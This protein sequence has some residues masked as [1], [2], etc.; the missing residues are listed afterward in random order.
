DR[1][2]DAND[3]KRLQ[4]IYGYY[5]DKGM[6]DDVADLFTSDATAEYANEGVYVGQPKIRSYLRKL[7]HDQIGL[8]FGEMHNHLILQPVV[9]VALDGATAK[10]RWRTLIQAGQFKQ[11]ATW[12]EGTYEVEYRKESG[13]WK[14]SQL[15]W[16]V[17]F[18]APYKG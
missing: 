7:G 14:I 13:V 1:L 6:W 15:H 11:N 16:Y 3:V 9:H 18:M 8:T 12:G 10:G 5:I 2:R 4:R 17:T